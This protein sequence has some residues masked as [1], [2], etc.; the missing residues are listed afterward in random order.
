[1]YLVVVHVLSRCLIVFL[2]FF[3]S[4]CWYGSL[5]ACLHPSFCSFASSSHSVF[6]RHVLTH[7]LYPSLSFSR[8]RFHPCSHPFFPLFPLPFSVLRFHLIILWLPL[9]RFGLLCP[10]FLL[11][12]SSSSFSLRFFFV[13]LVLVYPHSLLSPHVLLPSSTRRLNPS[14]HDPEVVPPSSPILSLVLFL[15][16]PPQSYFA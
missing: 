14:F 7:F 5:C 2:F 10:S 8:I 16:P 3:S 1:M 12:F 9:V 11:F 6:L 13:L 15:F 4:C